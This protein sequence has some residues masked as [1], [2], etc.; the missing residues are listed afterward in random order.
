MN[1][2]ERG[3]SKNETEMN[4]KS[5]SLQENKCWKGNNEYF[6]NVEKIVRLCLWANWKILK[7]GFGLLADWLCD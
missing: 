3:M 5:S 4:K 1:E 6:E 7:Y 2:N